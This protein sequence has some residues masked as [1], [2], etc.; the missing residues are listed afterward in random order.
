MKKYFKQNGILLVNESNN[1]KKGDV[2]AKNY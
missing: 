1:Y 2:N